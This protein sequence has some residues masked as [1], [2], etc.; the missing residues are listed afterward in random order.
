MARKLTEI[1]DSLALEKNNFA[2]LNGLAPSIDTTQDLLDDLNTTST[3]AKWRLML[4][5]QAVG[6]KALE[7]IFDLLTVEIQA[8]AD[9]GINA[10]I[11]WYVEEAKKFQFGDTLV[12]VTNPGETNGKF[13]YLAED[14]SKQIVEFAAAIDIDGLV[15]V[16]VAKDDGGGDPI[17][18]S[19]AELA[20]FGD[21]LKEFRV[22]GVT[23]SAVSLDGDDLRVDYK[24]VYDAQVMAADG[25]L[26]SA[27]GTFPVEDAINT[28][29]KSLPFNGV[30]NE[31]ALTDSIQLATGVIDPISNGLEAR[32]GANPFAPIVDNYDSAAGYL[33]WDEAGSTLTY[34]A[35]TL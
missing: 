35:D 31:T 27:P 7:E 23:T 13:V 1:Y 9:A 14:E 34:V 29:V 17:K 24:I 21:Y 25:S 8:T 28:F 3:V 32:S 12:F 20:A 26:L 2:V 4:F 19:V 11:P 6:I 10:T 5:V 16:K 22:A 18:L 33:V 30:L 15:R